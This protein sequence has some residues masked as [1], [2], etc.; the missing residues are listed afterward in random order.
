MASRL[1]TLL[2]PTR[3]NLNVQSGDHTAAL[4]T[5]A[6]LLVSHPDV[7][8]YDGFFDELLAREQL[9]L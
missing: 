5:V 4:Q 8:N 3:I 7:T 9:D 1:S 2:D 6:D